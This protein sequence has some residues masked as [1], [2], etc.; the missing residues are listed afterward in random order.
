MDEDF[1][2]W[3]G[4]QIDGDGSIGVYKGYPVVSIAKADK[5]AFVLK[6]IQEVQMKALRG[7]S[8]PVKTE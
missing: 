5:G 2:M 8:K 6:R 1:W 7:N 3:F 4:G